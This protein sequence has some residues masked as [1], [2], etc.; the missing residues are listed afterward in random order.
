MYLISLLVPGSPEAED[1]LSS[2]RQAV[3]RP[4]AAHQAGARGPQGQGR[5]QL[6]NTYFKHPPITARVPDLQEEVH[7]PESAHQQDPQA[8]AG[9]AV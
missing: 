9:G 3:F 2:V 6:S 4:Q 5:P 7:Q 8:A 1:G